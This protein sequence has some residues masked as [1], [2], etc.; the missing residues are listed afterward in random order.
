MLPRNFSGSIKSIFVENVWL[1][2]LALFNYVS[3]HCVETV[4]WLDYNQYSQL[5]RWCSGNASA[6]GAKGP[7]FNPGPGRG[8]MF[9]FLFLFVVFL[10]FFVQKHI[11]FYKCLQFLL[12]F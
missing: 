5:T 2:N 3:A 6:L 10:L 1:A 7:G 4:K 12:Q 11:I 8:L 9:D